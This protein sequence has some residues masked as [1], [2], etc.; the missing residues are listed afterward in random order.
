MH[1]DRQWRG[2][3]A[4]TR[5]AQR[6]REHGERHPALQGASARASQGRVQQKEVR[7]VWRGLRFLK[8]CLW[9]CSWERDPLPSFTTHEAIYVAHISITSINS[10]TLS[11]SHSRHA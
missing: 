1:T 11:L 8:G 10:P 9:L 5:G 6:P 4:R 7:D 2:R 3:S